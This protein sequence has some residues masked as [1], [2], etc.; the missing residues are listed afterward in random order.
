MT[1]GTDARFPKRLTGLGVER[2]A[3]WESVQDQFVTEN[4]RRARETA[5]CRRFGAIVLNDVASPNYLAAFRIECEDIALATE[6]IHDTVCHSRPRQP[7][8]LI[9]DSHF[10]F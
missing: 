9:L 5:E 3:A 4:Q 2:H 1:A 6:R 7:P 8:P 10:F